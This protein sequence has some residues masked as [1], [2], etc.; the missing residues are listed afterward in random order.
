M[1][2]HIQPIMFIFVSWSF[3]TFSS[4]S[5]LSHTF[6]PDIVDAEKENQGNGEQL[7]LLLPSMCSG[8]TI[9]YRGYSYTLHKNN[10]YGCKCRKNPKFL[11]KA[12]LALVGHP[13]KIDTRGSHGCNQGGLVTRSI[14]GDIHDAKLEMKQN[15]ED[16][17]VVDAKEP[18][19]TLARAYFKATAEKYH[20]RGQAI[21][22]LTV[23]Q[24]VSMIYVARKLAFG[25]VEESILHHPAASISADSDRLF[26]QF[27]VTVAVKGKMH[28]IIGH[29]HPGIYSIFSLLFCS[30]MVHPLAEW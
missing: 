29:G 22:S 19:N 24:L 1:M 20:A 15:V 17:C 9:V 27:Y 14:V 2:P 30:P 12:K 8:T 21:H 5:L 26:L 16:R 28:R 10:L 4:C 13:Q 23:D 18:V 6:V 11:C 7:E 3:V 25:S